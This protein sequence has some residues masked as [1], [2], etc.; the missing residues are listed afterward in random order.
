MNLSDCYQI[1]GLQG[2][3]SQKEIKNAYRRLSLKYH[4]DKNTADRDG[5]KFKEIKEAYQ[6]LREEKTR[7]K[8]SD[9]DVDTRYA[10]FWKKYDS[11]ASQEFHFGPNFDGFK[12]PFGANA[13]QNYSHFQQKDSS[14]KNTHMIIFGGL[15][16]IALWIILANIFK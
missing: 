2:G 11:K 7:M 16:L 3:A 14:H 9:K 6:Q 1:L 8:F 5:E 15:G 4:P 13:Q 10:E 12:N